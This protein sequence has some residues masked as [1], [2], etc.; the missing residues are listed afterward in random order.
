MYRLMLVDDESDIREGL[1]EVVDFAK[2]GFEVVGEAANGLEALQVAERQKPD[3]IVSDI[4]MPLMDGLTML[5]RVQQVLPT[6]RCL[7]LS[8]YDDFEY[9]RQAM[10]MN[11]L[12]YLLK[13]ISSTEFVEMLVEARKKLDE[14]FDARRNLSRLKQLFSESLPV[15]R[16]SLLSGLL[17]GGISPER[18]GTLAG[19]YDM[20]LDAKQ[21]VL[22][23]GRIEVREDAE[24]ALPEPELMELA[25]V[26]IAEERLSAHGR[27]YIFHHQEWL[28]ALLLLD[29]PGEDA[30]AQAVEWLDEARKSIDYYLGARTLVGVGTPCA[31]LE[32]L[33]GCAR[34][35][36]SALEQCAL[37]EDQPLLCASDLEPGARNS[38]T[39]SET[40]LRSL[41]NALRQSSVDDASQAL[42]RLMQVC[43]DAKP[44]RSAYRAYLLEIYLTLLHTARDTSASLTDQVSRALDRLLACPPP[45]VAREILGSLCRACAE[46]IRE[47]RATSSRMIACS[48]KE[49]IDQHYDDPKLTIEKLCGQLHVSPSY[50]SALFKKE[51]QETFLQRLT[52]VRMDKAMSLIMG[53]EMKTAQVAEAVG[54]PDPSYF[55]YAF[56]RFFGVSPSQARR[57]KE[58]RP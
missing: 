38:L 55:S 18:A 19:R 24:N 4:R 8:G 33:P 5:R 12:G 16:E 44:S 50:F 23:L 49:Y 46:E 27:T 35:A 11:C 31:S 26:G 6:V 17:A 1:Q 14:E 53:T 15:L 48:A 40:L 20:R 3:L 9:A 32:G 57:R 58:D 51:T 34:Q 36:L 42:D 13:P 43:A 22:A 2:Y 45:E 21:Y 10:T 30:Y 54:V 29:A 25:A 47:N 7:I 41:G 39:V 52:A 37:W 56:K 28:A